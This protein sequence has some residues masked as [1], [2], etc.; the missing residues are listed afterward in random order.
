[1][2]S[3][4]MQTD[5]FRKVVEKFDDERANNKNVVEK[6]NTIYYGVDSFVTYTITHKN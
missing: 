4:C 1:M 5:N 3:L 6:S 2:H